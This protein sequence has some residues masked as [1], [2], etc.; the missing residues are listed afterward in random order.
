MK[1]P[2][3]FEEERFG[4]HATYCILIS[5]YGTTLETSNTWCGR[6][7]CASLLKTTVS[8][9]LD[10]PQQ[11]D[12]HDSKAT[13]VAGGLMAQYQGVPRVDS[14]FAMESGTWVGSK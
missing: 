12:D 13:T 9:S 1:L 7:R 6:C 4:I 14:Q 2:V 11:K 3:F 5:L 8:C 10:H